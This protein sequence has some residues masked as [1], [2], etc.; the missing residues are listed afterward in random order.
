M[1]YGREPSTF[2]ESSPTLV[3][4]GFYLKLFDTKQKAFN[5]KPVSGFDGAFLICT[6]LLLMVLLHA[7]CGFMFGNLEIWHL[8]AVAVNNNNNKGC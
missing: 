2:Y 6:H 7:F 8:L 1:S 4:V 5:I 3:K